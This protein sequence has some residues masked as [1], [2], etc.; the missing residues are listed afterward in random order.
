MIT[1]VDDDGELHSYIRS[2][3]HMATIHIH[4]YVYI[5]TCLKP[6]NSLFYS[7]VVITV[8]FHNERYSVNEDDGIVQP[9]L[10]L[11]N[12]SSFVETVQVINTDVTA[13]GEVA[14]YCKLCLAI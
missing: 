2:Y 14:N 8:K 6:L 12:P 13:N 11:S 7:V 3:M 10:V 9:L 5:C 1:I 4:T